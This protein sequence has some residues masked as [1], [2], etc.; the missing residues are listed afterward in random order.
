M[1]DK[2]VSSYKNSE[3]LSEGIKKKLQANKLNLQGSIQI[4][5]QQLIEDN[6]KITHFYNTVNYNEYLCG[7][8]LK[9]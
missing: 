4:L 8:F 5:L 7:L 9:Y 1:Y 3:E 2:V 6:P